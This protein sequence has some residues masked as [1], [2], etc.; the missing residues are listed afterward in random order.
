MFSCSLGEI[1]LK[2][3]AN[4]LSKT[5]QNSLISAAQGQEIAHVVIE[6]LWK[7]RCDETYGLF[8]SNLINKK[9]EVD[10]ASQICHV[11]ESYL[12]FIIPKVQVTVFTMII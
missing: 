4:N 2:K 5:L 8:W 6:M 10:V 3:Q 1:I 12:I 9:S 11:E 7:D